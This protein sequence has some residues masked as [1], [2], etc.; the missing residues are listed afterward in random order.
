M[1]YLFGSFFQA[2]RI[3]SHLK[4][5]NKFMNLTVHD[6]RQV[7]YRESN[8]VVRNPPLRVIVGSDFGTPVARTHQRFAVFG[9][10][11]VP[12]GASRIPDSGAQ[13]LQSLIVVLVLGATVLTLDYG[14]GGQVGQPNTRFRF[15]HVLTAGTAGTKGVFADVRIVDLYVQF[16]RF[17]QYGNRCGGSVHAALAFRGRNALNAVHSG[18]VL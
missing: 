8:S 14:I 3:L 11:L 16:V 12:F 9:N 1:G 4:F 6:L 13:D 17:R 5:F 10:G 18:F 7:V 2:F 15:V